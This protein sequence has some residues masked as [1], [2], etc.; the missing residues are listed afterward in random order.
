DGKKH[1]LPSDLQQT[2][3][4]ALSGT[5][6]QLWQVIDNYTYARLGL[7][8]GATM[9]AN[10]GVEADIKSMPFWKNPALSRG[11]SLN[12]FSMGYD[13]G[14]WS[15][16]GIKGDIIEFQKGEKIFGQGGGGVMTR[17]IFDEHDAIGIFYRASV[18]TEIPSVGKLT[19]DKYSQVD[20]IYQ[21]LPKDQNKW[22]F[23]G[24]IMAGGISPS[25]AA[26]I[27]G[28][29]VFSGGWSG[30][31]LGLEVKGERITT[32][33]IKEEEKVIKRMG[34]GAILGHAALPLPELTAIALT[35]SEDY[36]KRV[37]NYLSSA[38]GYE[39]DHEDDKSKRIGLFA[40]G[41]YL[42]S[43][44]TTGIR[45]NL[46]SGA[47]SEEEAKT[48]N[49]YGS[50]MVIGWYQKH[51]IL[52]GAEKVPYFIDASQ[53]IEQ[54]QQALVEN[55]E[56]ARAIMES[57]VSD[58]KGLKSAE[59]TKFAFGYGWDDRVYV[60]AASDFETM[61]GMRAI[62]LITGD[63]ERDK[64]WVG[65]AVAQITHYSNPAILDT[66]ARLS[67]P[68][69]GTR[70]L[71]RASLG[72]GPVFA[73]SIPLKSGAFGEPINESESSKI[74]TIRKVGWT[75]QGILRTY[76]SS[77]PEGW[78]VLSGLM[79]STREI[80]DYSFY[81]VSETPGNS[82]SGKRRE[83]ELQILPIT[84]EKLIKT[85]GGAF[86]KTNTYLLID[87]KNRKVYAMDSSSVDTNRLVKLAAVDESAWLFTVGFNKSTI[88]PKDIRGQRTVSSSGW[89]M[90]VSAGPLNRKT[91]ELPIYGGAS[92]A[93]VA[94]GAG[95]AW[96]KTDETSLV[97]V[98]SSGGI[99]TQ[100]NFFTVWDSSQSNLAFTP[101]VSST[102]QQSKNPWWVGAYVQLKF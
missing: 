53:R 79:G 42:H 38:Y 57:A 91:G 18:P 23:F 73:A 98:G 83:S 4:T 87:N 100:P 66:L 67:F 28:A 101:L 25:D 44:L 32:V 76:R 19:E 40:G 49:D 70:W 94:G 71:S 17:N 102:D 72:A 62:A 82:T 81:S 15:I 86:D 77:D 5:M 68:L 35:S 12:G 37:E 39:L 75:Y 65:E 24:R 64:Q 50:A 59:R 3:V 9:P 60:I 47:I 96:S 99:G 63:P 46:R 97:R 20:I 33:K 69:P 16:Y 90:I 2:A 11:T 31:T 36:A 48:A 1:L 10:Q 95:V 27:P 51:S 30:A 89:D 92:K 52:I 22:A 56:Y 41:T 45:K 88:I 6:G 93:S 54:A 13:L 84:A 34:Y 21:R 26:L 80:N 14:D 85:S 55:P 7:E 29:A 58:I 8:P 61:A 78:E 43:I 74:G